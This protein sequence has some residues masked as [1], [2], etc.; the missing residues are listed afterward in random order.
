MSKM[1]VRQ[2]KPFPEENSH[3]CPTPEAQLVFPALYGGET[4]NILKTGHAKWNQ[5]QNVT[6]TVKGHGMPFF[7]NDD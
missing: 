1:A 3:Q 2:K 7:L 5:Q 4:E 6:P